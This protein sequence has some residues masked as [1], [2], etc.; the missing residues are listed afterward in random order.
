M[1]QETVKLYGQAY[2][3]SPMD[4]A[5]LK[6]FNDQFIRLLGTTDSV[7]RRILMERREA[8]LNGIMAIKYKL[9]DAKFRGINPGDGELGMSLPRWPF[10]KYNDSELTN[11]DTTVA[12]TWGRWMDKSDGTGYPLGEDWGY[13]ITHLTSLV[14]PEPLVRQVRFEIGRNI[15]VPYDV[16][17]IIL[18][19]N[20]NR[21]AHWPIPTMYVLPEDTF[22]SKHIGVAGTEKLIPGGLVVGLGRALKVETTP[23]W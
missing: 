14:T 6:I 16:S 12:A 1:A 13:I 5:E 22:L 17:N 15:L 7:H 3:L 4:A 10:Y 9:N 20:E 19:D 2:N 18:G 23:S 11:W 8:I 21:V